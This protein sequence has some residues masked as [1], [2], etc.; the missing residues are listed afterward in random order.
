MAFS[1]YMTVAFGGSRAGLTTVGYAIYEADGSQIGGRV[2]AGIDDIGDGQY[3]AT[4]TMPTGFRGRITWDTGE[5][6][7]I[8]VSV[9]IN[10]E[11]GEMVVQIKDSLTGPG[12]TPVD[13]DFGGTDRLTYQTAAGVGIG[14]AD[15][16]AYL[17][18]QYD[19]GYK[20]RDYVIA[21]TT[22]VATG[23]W[24]KALMLAPGAYTLIYHKSGEYGPDRADIVVS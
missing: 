20:T 2:A 11:E 5:A 15:V 3:A 18:A 17:T 7:P 6:D 16:L 10:P 24:A 13:H 19:A 8:T 4:V 1:Q 23:R 9:P 21:W 12:Q 14:G 22:T